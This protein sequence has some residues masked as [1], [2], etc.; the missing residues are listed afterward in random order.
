[1]GGEKVNGKGE[2]GLREF[3][4]CR[5][6][7]C[8]IFCVAVAVARRRSRWWL[9]SS[10]VVGLRF[11]DPRTGSRSP[12]FRPMHRNGDKI[13]AQT[14]PWR[15]WIRDQSVAGRGS[16]AEKEAHERG[17]GE[18]EG[19]RERDRAGVLLL[20]DPL[21]ALLPKC[22]TFR[23][24]VLLFLLIDLLFPFLR[25][26]DPFQID[27]KGLEL[28]EKADNWGQ[29]GSVLQ[30]ISSSFFSFP[31]PLRWTSVSGES[32]QATTPKGA[33][34]LRTISIVARVR[35]DKGFE[36]R[37]PDT[38]VSSEKGR[39]VGR[40]RG[41]DARRSREVSA[42]AAAAAA[43]RTTSRRSR[44][45]AEHRRGDCRRRRGQGCRARIAR[46]LV[47]EDHR[48]REATDKEGKSASPFPKCE[49]ILVLQEKRRKK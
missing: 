3:F 10:V 8:L 44:R 47:D 36:G 33:K 17:G 29:R 41:R 16:E 27:S 45:H 7:A 25:S 28:R 39:P 26:N 6:A 11:A 12:Q 18:R 19:E 35:G 23:A 15:G 24:R 42:A 48:C 32:K 20:L 31:L 1:M 4:S 43:K 49:Q 30:S 40:G 37:C 38:Q 2:R 5:G 22:D 21:L 34:A 14:I 46:H 13:H 9:P